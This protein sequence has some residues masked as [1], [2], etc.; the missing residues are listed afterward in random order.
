MQFFG[1]DFYQLYDVPP[2]RL[3]ALFVA[4]FVGFYW[5]GLILFRPILRQF[6]KDTP[7][8]NDLVGYVLSCFCVF[9]GLLLGLIA[10]TAYQNVSDAGQ[11][12][13]REAAALSALYE[14]VSRYPEPHRQS[15]RWLLRDYTRYVIRYAWPLQQQGIVPEEGTIRSEAFHEKLLDFQPRTPGEEILHAEAMR[16]FNNFLECR[17]MRL[18][19]VR[20]A[21][22]LSMWY[23]MIVGAVLNMAICWLFD[24]RF[25]TQLILGGIIA[26]YLGTMMHLIFDMNQPFRGDV[27]ITAESFE[28]LY[29]RMNEE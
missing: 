11:N 9:Y 17:R 12:V 7:G 13:T 19:S 2:A 4:A 18:L 28:S 10:V 6:V 14:D 5:V 24:M 3:A 29:Q 15:L 22:P 25:I 27:S 23:V 20:S 21:L 26:A 16:Q 8:A 1:F